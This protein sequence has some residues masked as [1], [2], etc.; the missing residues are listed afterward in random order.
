MLGKGTILNQ[1]GIYVHHDRLE[2]VGGNTRAV[3]LKRLDVF[4]LLRGWESNETSDFG[5]C[6]LREANSR[7]ICYAEL[8]AIRCES[9]E[10]SMK[11]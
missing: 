5:I 10:D 8:L 6:N 9:A 3:D 11:T 2:K 1:H 7:A 4:Q